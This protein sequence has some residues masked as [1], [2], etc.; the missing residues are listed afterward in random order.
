MS[1]MNRVYN[2]TITTLTPLH[3]G[4]GRT[5]LLDYDYVKHHG[6]TWVINDE[7]LAE[8]LMDDK[9]A[10]E[11]MV[12]GAPARDLLDIKDFNPDS[13]LFRYVLKGEPR[14][15]KRGSGVQELLKNAW[16]EPYIPGS[17][18][19][20][21]LRTAIAFYGW[22]NRGL[23][24]DVE[25]LNSRA[26]FAALAMENQVLFSQR[27]KR[28]NDPNYDLL[29]A[30]QVSDSTPDRGKSLQLLNV[31]VIKS[32]GEAGAP[33]EIE[34]IPI[35]QTF[36]ARLVIDE[37]LRAKKYINAGGAEVHTRDTLGWNKDDQALWLRNLPMLVNTFTESRLNKENERWQNTSGSVRG[38]YREITRQMANLA[39][40]EFILQLGW[41][42]GWDSKTFGEALTADD[43]KF[44]KI[45][46]KYE[47]K[48]V[49]QGSFSPGDR[50]P[51]SRRLMVNEGNNPLLPLGWVK[52]KMEE[53]Q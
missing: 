23:V 21:A 1:K 29:R 48:M 52:V 32:R 22:F 51:K 6:R 4:S 44:Y 47:Q 12:S 37:F 50:F 11:R 14:A 46:K 27:A 13:S 9:S 43:K 15:E 42:G 45:V 39:N 3:I 18:L 49:R 2:L 17:S 19:K 34:A 33:I 25:S 7:A 36:T 24:V 16:D 5:L 53:T 30:L 10:F 41:G 8:M 26:Q 38:F 20:G 31:S 35:D 28:K 40:N